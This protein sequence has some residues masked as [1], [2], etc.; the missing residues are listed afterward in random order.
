[1]KNNQDNDLSDNKLTNKNS[2][3]IITIP[4]DDNHVS[5]KNYIDDELNKNTIFRF[6]QTS[7]IYLKVS[8]GNDT[9]NLTKN[10]KIK[11]YRYD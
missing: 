6:N 5:N 4:T 9:Y 8:V 3:T 2:I 7:Q 11:I 1:M 10:N